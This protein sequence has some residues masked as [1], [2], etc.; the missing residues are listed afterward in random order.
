MS[1]LST[2][3]TETIAAARWAKL[4]RERAAG[5]EGASGGPAPGRRGRLDRQ[6][7]FYDDDIS[8]LPVEV[9]RLHRIATEINSRSELREVL[10]NLA[11]VAAEEA[12]AQMSAIFL[13]NDGLNLR[14]AAHRALP[15]ELAEEWSLVRLGRGVCGLAAMKSRVVVVEDVEN[16]PLTFADRD[17]F[18]RAGIRSAWAVPLL[19]HEEN[20]IGAVATYYTHVHR[21]D[22]RDI[23][24]AQLYGLHASLAIENAWLHDQ[25][26]EQAIKDGKTGLFNHDHFLER[27]RLELDRS[28]RRAGD[29]SLLMI[30][31]DDYKRYNDTCGHL[32]GDRALRIIGVVLR[33][34]ARS[35]DI[36]ARYGGEE[37]TFILPDTDSEGAMTM[38]ER[39]RREVENEMFPDAE[40]EPTV[41]LTVSVGVAVWPQDGLAI[42]EI[43][44]AADA[45]LYEAKRAGKNRVVRRMAPVQAEH[46][47]L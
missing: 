45:G 20:V 15:D 23:F 35:T 30:D 9:A 31:I 38:G 6:A 19:G 14:L 22:R 4:R 12:R 36:A 10:S 7:H 44:G 18:R 33:R 27:L 11:K 42:D 32:M 39:V 29:L 21:P 34:I 24:M 46:S 47:G 25:L 13:L 40:G 17:R 43:V 2:G 37:F 16:D 28:R 3:G 1:I 8:R 41:R 5:A 26:K